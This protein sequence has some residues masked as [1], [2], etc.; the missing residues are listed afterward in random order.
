VPRSDIDDSEREYDRL[1]QMAEEEEVTVSLTPT[2]ERL[3]KK[4]NLDEAAIRDKM[5]PGMID[6]LW[7][8]VSSSDLPSSEQ[9]TTK[10]V[11]YG[12]SRSD[13]GSGSRR[14][15]AFMD[16]EVPVKGTPYRVGVASTANT[17]LA[18]AK[19]PR[20]NSSGGTQLPHTP[21]PKRMLKSAMKGSKLSSPV[22]TPMPRKSSLRQTPHRAHQ[23]KT[24]SVPTND[25][26][27]TDNRDL[28]FNR[29]H[30]S[31]S[32]E[33]QK[34]TDA[35]ASRAEVVFSFD[36]P[37][38][39]SSPS[40]PASP[41]G[42]P[43]ITG[44]STPKR[45]VSIQRTISNRPKTPAAL[46]AFIARNDYH[47]ATDSESTALST[48]LY[49]AEQ[50]H[51]RR[52]HESDMHRR[53]LVDP[54]GVASRKA[55]PEAADQ[56]VVLEKR[57]LL[58]R[59][60]S[61]LLQ[62]EDE[63]E[64]G[65]LEVPAEGKSGA[66]NLT[67]GHAR[68]AHSDLSLINA[69]QRTKVLRTGTGTKLRASPDDKNIL[70]RTLSQL[71]R[72]SSQTDELSSTQKLRCETGISVERQPVSECSDRPQLHL[73]AP[74][75]LVKDL[76]TVQRRNAWRERTPDLELSRSAH[77][78]L[79]TAARLH[80]SSPLGLASEAYHDVGDAGDELLGDDDDDEY[81][82]LDDIA[83]S[84]YGDTEAQKGNKISFRST[85]PEDCKSPY[86][87]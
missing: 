49:Q 16:F 62:S 14:A 85:N 5:F 78:P 6:M 48:P 29:S 9:S 51:V 74:R 13:M 50:S 72:S 3:G 11:E 57:P 73:P 70:D 66:I 79:E 87:Q 19:A 23:A 7:P 46:Q 1:I 52:S 65:S 59:T 27:E 86:H 26:P 83:A 53:R 42:M 44:D 41:I 75:A 76:D 84:D 35:S 82:A 25:L 21:V 71:L 4:P 15:E 80:A 45:R 31:R 33:E 28:T 18:T 24:P 67:R 43:G 81:E 58:N 17:A 61:Q 54:S 8:V 37:L 68:T 60:L 56:T 32:L 2:A 69:K 36:Q 12:D 20:T 39:G 30:M 63:D 38:R 55:S 22:K 77:R 34:V 64:D 47:S 40:E 10:D